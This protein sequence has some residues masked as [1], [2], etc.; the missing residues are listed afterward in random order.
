MLMYSG[1]PK[2]EPPN[3]GPIFHLQCND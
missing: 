2:A 1:Q 3:C